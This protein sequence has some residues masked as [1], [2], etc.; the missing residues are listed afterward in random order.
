MAA[1]FTLQD[2]GVLP[3]FVGEL[4]DFE[5]A[6]HAVNS[7]RARSDASI[8]YLQP[9][10]TVRECR[11]TALAA[12]LLAAP[13]HYTA[14]LRPSDILL[15]PRE[16][17]ISIEMESCGA[18]RFALAIIVAALCTSC[19]TTAQRKEQAIRENSQLASSTLHR[20]IRAVYDSADYAPLRAHIPA[21]P[22]SFTLELLTD[23]AFATDDEIRALFAVHPKV[24][25]CRQ[26]QLDQ[27]M[28]QTR[29][30]VPIMASAYSRNEDALIGLIQQQTT[31]GAY[32]R[33]VKANQEE[34]RAKL[35]SEGQR[36]DAGLQKSHEAEL[37]RRQAAA[38]AI[39]QF[40]ETAAE[41]N[42]LSR[43]IVT[44]CNAY[45]NSATCVTH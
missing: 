13:A 23:P 10:S 18:T 41:I 16:A 27:I 1:R 5:S 29:S 37:A 33:Q 20:C 25:A 24:N 9:Q 12:I 15:T 7:A 26:E 4:F 35:V 14:P 31:W 32:A 45:G 8:Q 36:I 19:S 30:F 21:P 44:N 2:Q 3:E 34:L 39:A 17:R 11:P 22:S 42:A 40:V 38:N 43:P 28:Q 6:A